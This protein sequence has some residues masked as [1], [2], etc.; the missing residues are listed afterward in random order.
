MRSLSIRKGTLSI[1]VPD[2]VAASAGD[3]EFRAHGHAWALRISR[4]DLVDF[5]G[6]GTYEQ[7]GPDIDV[8]GAVVDGPPPWWSSGVPEQIESA[9]VAALFGQSGNPVVLGSD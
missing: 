4:D 9:R 2:A 6:V 7:D 3:V 5:W 8:S 1:L